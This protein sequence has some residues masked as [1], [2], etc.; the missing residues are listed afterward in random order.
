MQI[1]GSKYTIFGTHQQSYY[2]ESSDEHEEELKEAY[3]IFYVK[4]LKLRETH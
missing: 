2:S 1:K 4:F 3:K